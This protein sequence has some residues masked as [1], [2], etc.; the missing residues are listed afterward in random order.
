MVN[1]SIKK[2]CSTD[3]VNIYLFLIFFSID[4]AWWKKFFSIDCANI[5]LFSIFFSIDFARW[6]SVGLPYPRL[7]IS[8]FITWLLITLITLLTFVK[9]NWY[10]CT[11]FSCGK[12]KQKIETFSF[13]RD[14]VLES[15]R[16]NQDPAGTN[17]NSPLIYQVSTR[18]M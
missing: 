14:A 4:F 2:L 13:S 1:R 17:Q 8:W 5:Y 7:F 11:T 12:I 9:F 3:H 10:N 16:T 15:S 18:I 6:K